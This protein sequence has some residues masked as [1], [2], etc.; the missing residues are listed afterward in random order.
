MYK[1]IPNGKTID[2]KVASHTMWGAGI[3]EKSTGKECGVYDQK[4]AMWWAG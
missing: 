2:T 3:W 1:Q 4:R